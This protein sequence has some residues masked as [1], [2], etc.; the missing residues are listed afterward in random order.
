MHDQLK[1]E[2]LS[3]IIDKYPFAADFF[4]GF[5]V[6]INERDKTF[7]ELISNFNDSF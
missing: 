4:S 5:G 2:S 6:E 1:T 7:D 3:D